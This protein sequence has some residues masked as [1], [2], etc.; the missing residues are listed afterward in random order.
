MYLHILAGV[1][2]PLSNM[3]LHILAGVSGPFFVML[4]LSVG[5]VGSN[6]INLRLSI[7]KKKYYA[8]Y[9][10][11]FFKLLVLQKTN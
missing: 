1:S 6:N 9:F 10:L 8:I 5:N 3:Y 2:G 11:H 7:D 4:Q